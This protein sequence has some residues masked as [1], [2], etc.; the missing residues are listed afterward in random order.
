MRAIP[1][2][3]ETFM[4][5]VQSRYF[6]SSDIL[7]Q[8]DFYRVEPVKRSLAVESV[9]LQIERKPAEELKLGDQSVDHEKI[10]HQY[11]GFVSKSK[12]N[13]HSSLVLDT[14]DKD[15]S[16]QAS[17]DQLIETRENEIMQNSLKV[18]IPL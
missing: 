14:D 4:L 6:S 9:P 5:K 10:I 16:Q 17:F 12:V 7:P 18:S 13:G 8:E 11:E 15:T 3:S 2:A 1:T